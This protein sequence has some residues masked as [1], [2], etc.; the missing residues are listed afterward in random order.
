MSDDFNGMNLTN[1]E[2]Y[3]VASVHEM[4]LEEDEDFTDWLEI[5]EKVDTR[6]ME[7]LS[8]L[9]QAYSHGVSY[10]SHDKV[11]WVSE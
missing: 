1:L 3:I 8:D 6:E 2:N 10:E 11:K 7:L 4:S 5:D 9:E